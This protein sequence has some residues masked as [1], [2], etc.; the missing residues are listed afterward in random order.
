MQIVTQAALGQ[1]PAIF[2]R[3][4]RLVGKRRWQRRARS[5]RDEIR[6]NRYLE[7]FLL[8]ENRIVIALDTYSA[9]KERYGN[10]PG[11]QILD[12]REYEAVSFVTQ[13]LTFI[14]SVEPPEADRFLGRVQG[15]FE[16]PDDSRAL[17]FELAMATHLG[18]SGA[19]IH[20]PRDGGTYDWFCE[21]KELPFEVECKSMSPDKGR[22]I[23]LRGGLAVFHLVTKELGKILDRL[24]GGLLL[25]I[26]VPGRLPSAHSDQKRIATLAKEAVLSAHDSTSPLAS[27]SQQHFVA[28]DVPMSDRNALRRFLHGRFAIDNQQAIAIQRGRGVLVMVVESDMPDDVLGETMEALRKAAREQLTG[29]AA[30]LL[31]AKLEGLTADELTELGTVKG[32][33]PSA[34]QVRVNQLMSSSSLNHVVR[35]VFLADG[36]VTRTATGACSRVGASY[37][38]WNPRSPLKDDAR[39]RLFDEG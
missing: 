9:H 24:I 36:D 22:P 14:D 13:C 16:N 23:H 33:H 34:L 25:R 11:I 2:D 17:A 21:R 20:L 7:E 19:A 1:F 38:F 12:P 26:R 8:R 37:A 29:T 27:V 4:E 39:L 5:I 31:C 18:R 10:L 3:F 30:G 28:T 35:V 15:S 6:G 32:G